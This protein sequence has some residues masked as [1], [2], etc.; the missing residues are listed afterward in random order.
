MLKN[1]FLLGLLTWV[2]FTYAKGPSIVK[3]NF[4]ESENYRVEKPVMEQD[5][6]RGVAGDKIKKKKPGQEPAAEKY[7][8][9]KQSDSDVRY[10]QYSE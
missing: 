7:P 5:A 9:S 8:K 2:S 10:W 4:G 3:E 6:Q 1:L